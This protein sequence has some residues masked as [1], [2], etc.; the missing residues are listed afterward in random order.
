MIVK[1]KITPD[2]FYVFKPT[3]KQGF[4]PI[5][6]KNLGR[7]T[8]KYIFDKNGGLKEVDSSESKRIKV[9]F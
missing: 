7:K 3:L 5:I 4:K 6:V 8:K 9:F 2:Q 1:G